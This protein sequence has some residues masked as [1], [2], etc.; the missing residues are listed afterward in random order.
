MNKLIF[1]I[2]SELPDYI[3]DQKIFSDGIVIRADATDQNV[4]NYVK[5]IS[6]L[7]FNLII[8][9]PPYGLIVKN[10][11]DQNI[12]D[13]EK[14]S[15]WLTNWVVKWFS[16]LEDGAAAYVFGGTGK[17]FF[18]PF[19]R[20]CSEI[21]HKTNGNITLHNY[22]SWKKKRAIGS[23][24]N[25][26]YCR[27]E[28]ALLLKTINIDKPRI[29]NIPYTDKLRGYEGYNPKY[30]CKSPYL[31]FSNIWD[32]SEIFKGKKHIC[33]KPFEVCAIPIRT[34]TNEGDIILDL[35]AGSA[36]TAV[37]ARKLKRKFISI[38]LGE[39]EY[40][41]IVDRLKE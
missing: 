5:N 14:F 13:D 3:L 24:Y 11:W 25:Y 2:P 30:K 7:P 37:A 40:N 12:K 36:A 21:E 27:E 18:R 20:F 41:T 10:E 8:S 28:I 4:I 6:K 33:E 31:R 32:I 26:L 16:I 9:D 22:I 23:K 35:F 39:R 38:E 19:F 34:H 17:K 29:F 1:N 15:N